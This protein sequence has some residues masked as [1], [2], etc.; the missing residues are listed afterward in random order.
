MSDFN[1]GRNSKVKGLERETSHGFTVHNSLKELHDFFTLDPDSLPG[2]SIE[3]PIFKKQKPSKKDL[4][5]S[6]G[7]IK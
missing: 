5:R 2:G 7:K 1:S 4:D 3:P 6:E